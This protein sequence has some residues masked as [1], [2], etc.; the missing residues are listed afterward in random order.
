MDA[1]IEIETSA[2]PTACMIWLHGLGADGHDFEGLI[3][4]LRLPPSLALR[5]VF[6][7]APFRPVTINGGAVMRA[8]YD[9][10]MNDGGLDQNMG[11]VQEST[12]FLSGLIQQQLQRGMEPERILLG[13][14]SQGGA[15]AMHTGLTYPQRLAGILSLSAPLPDARRLMDSIHEK[16]IDLPIFV[17]HGKDDPLI[18][19]SSAQAVYDQ[20]KN[21]DMNVE[22][23]SYPMGHAV[24]PE[25]IVDVARWL[26]QVLRR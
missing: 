9:I 4:Q 13:G 17:A 2:S 12:E 10:A 15:I 26:T 23:H 22:W 19:F 6:P 1:P 24:I 7:H 21:Q 11:H 25:E 16:N 18:P 5:F 8:W 3:P 14:F 20:L